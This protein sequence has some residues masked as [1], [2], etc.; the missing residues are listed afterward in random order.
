MTP[1][2]SRAGGRGAAGDPRPG[3]ADDRHRRATGRS[4]GP[5]FPRRVSGPLGGR[6]ADWTRGRAAGG[7][8]QTSSGSSR[9]AKVQAGSSAVT[10]LAVRAAS[11]VR[12]L[13]D[14]PLLDRVVRGR[15][16]IPLLGVLL[17]GIVAMQV[18]VLKLGA[19]IGR[20]IERSSALQSRNQLLRQSVAQLSSEQRIERLAAGLG[21]IMPPPGA[22]GFLSAD[23]SG[24]V[25][26]ALAGIHAPDPAAF[27]ANQSANGGVVISADQTAADSSTT[28]TSTASTPTSAA[29]TATSTALPATPASTGASA[30]G[31]APAQVVPPAQPGVGTAGVSAPQG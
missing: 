23:Q 29:S 28:A 4:T 9:R 17:A 8:A 11:F 6:T 31:A 16:W 27:T 14:H 3:T 15:A 20:S 10:G 18:E 24:S 30:L 26:Q 1:P 22:V 19:S 7:R 12:A 2:A 25:Q 13:P 5:K 21:M